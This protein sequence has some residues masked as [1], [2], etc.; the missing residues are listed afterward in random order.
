MTCRLFRS[1]PAVPGARWSVF[2][3]AVLAPA[4]GAVAAGPVFWDQPQDVS[5]ADGELRGAGLDAQGRLVPGLTA[6]VVLADSSLVV[7]TVMSTADGVVHAGSGHDGRVWRLREG[8][9]PEVLAELPVQ[10]VFA[11]L[12]DGEDLLAGC[13][14]E[15]AVYRVRPD[16]T[17]SREV[18]VPGGYVWDLVRGHDGA[19]YAA[20]GNPAAVYRLGDGQARLVAELPASNALDLAVA[21]DGALLVAAQGPGRV[22]RVD[23]DDDSW[24]LLVAMEQDEV[25]QLVR[26]ADGWYALG[27][28]TEEGDGGGNGSGG[29]QDLSFEGP[30]D[31][32]VTA[33]RQVEPVRSALV[34]LDG[35]APVRV[36]TSEDVVTSVAWSDD[37]GWLGAG[38]R[39]RGQL[40]V[41]SGL[42][43]PNGRRPLASWEGGDV[44]RIVVVPGDDGPDQLLVAQANPGGVTR[45]R[46][47]EGR[48]AVALSA[49]L[50]A[51]LTVQWGRL[52][53]RG[54]AGGGEPRFAVR[55]GNSATPDASW[56]DWRE[57]GSGHDLDLADLPPR[58]ALQWRVTLAGGSR[59]DAVSV[60]ALAPNLAP[61][62]TSFSLEPRGELR[63]GGLMNGGDSV[64]EQLAGGLQVEYG[65]NSQRERR[66]DRRRAAALRPVRSLTW[67]ARDPNEDRLRARVFFRAQGEE[68]WRPIGG[69]T[70][71]QV[72]AWDTA[73]LPDGW[74]EL[75]L[76][77]SDHPDNPAASARTTEQVLGPVPVDNTAP[78]LHDW[79]LE[80]LPEGFSVAFTARDA[81]G[82]LA[83]AEV[84][85]PDGRTERLDPRDG[86]CDSAEESFA[87]SVPFPQPWG[88][89][90]SRPW[91]VRVQVWD[92]Q[93][94]LV[95]RDGLLP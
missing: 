32:M 64:T 50:D 29:S 24:E 27:Y 41:L 30:F 47:S 52:T 21:G 72:A 80:R 8:R 66:V 93:G 13:G 94:N 7:W 31:L 59:V 88:E 76:L 83:G 57:L 10:E 16:G 11:L 1:L 79:R 4:V 91:S 26:G 12:A 78:G 36:W 89:P 54:P 65:V 95:V 84:V 43:A 2:L 62:I 68:I 70:V 20:G 63:R 71:E 60:S 55:A 51:G 17:S 35:P 85:L 75:R 86:I 92:L 14:P 46:A 38:S 34:R 61:Q 48:Q 44:L 19:V 49:P 87:V 90:V 5:F 23:P 56:T 42:D 77:V 82:P 3:L 74:Y 73:A 6:E 81:F 28:Q 40:T 9:A 69:A 25:R 33:D 67:H 37:H 18:P 53:W 39:E 58:R 15:G 22:F 45:L